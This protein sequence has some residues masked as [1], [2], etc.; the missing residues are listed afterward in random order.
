M[1]AELARAIL[2]QGRKD[3]THEAPIPEDDAKAI[4]DA[5]DL[6]DMA[7][8]A[9]DQHVRGPEVEVLLRMAAEAGNG[10]GPPPPPEELAAGVEENGSGDSAETQA[11]DEAPAPEAEQTPDD[12][13]IDVEPWENFNEESVSTVISGIDAALKED[14]AE[15]FGD[16]MGH[17]WT[18]E[19]AH[20]N[21]A[22]V[23][24]HLERVAK[25]LAKQAQQE[26]EAAEDAPSEPEGQS[27][28][29]PEQAP[30]PAPAP[31]AEVEAEASP[32]QVVE[33][34]AAAPSDGA[35]PD[36]AEPVSNV[37][38][39][40]PRKPGPS[41]QQQDQEIDYTDLVRLIE[42]ELTAER[43]HTPEPPVETAPQLPWD[44]TKMTDGELQKFHGMFSAIAYYKN[45]VLAREERIGLACKMA[46]DELHNEL[47]IRLPK[48][49]E[50]D[51]EKRVALIEAEV[52]NDEN[53]RKWR[54]RQRKHETFAAA[55]RHER[56][57]IA[58]LVEALS[59]HETMR[60]DEWERA[61][62]LGDR[63]H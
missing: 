27:E 55:H 5:E 38:D 2:A 32:G 24:D 60:H 28:P 33:V 42:T 14:S 10:D 58:R 39:L 20:K 45:Y 62:K 13:L 44:W 53:I 8:T 50:R 54:R 12:D 29:E 61:G 30:P 63:R 11:E 7:Q 23:L 52:E 59:R 36:E 41:E 1:N 31:E 43:V 3:G 26:K 19:Q 37:V 49:D 16:L 35:A 25:R 51:K 17:V 18:Y 57:S 56:D 22:T 6:I 4:A 21:R 15:D 40:P 9:W 46:A 47:M 34:Q 48:Y